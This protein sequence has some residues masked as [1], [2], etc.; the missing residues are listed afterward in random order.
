MRFSSGGNF[1]CKAKGKDEPSEC[2]FILPKEEGSLRFVLLSG[3]EHFTSAR[4]D[5]DTLLSHADQ[6]S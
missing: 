3:T 1:V 4:S 2:H 6:A 5:N